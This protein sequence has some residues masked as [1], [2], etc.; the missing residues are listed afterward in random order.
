[1]TSP[2]LLMRDVSMPELQGN[3]YGDVVQLAIDREAAI[4][5]CN[6]SMEALREWADNVGN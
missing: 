4:K 3:T 2:A 1:M 6:A 5:Q